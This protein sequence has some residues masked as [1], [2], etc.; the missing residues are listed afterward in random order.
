[1]QK[2]EEEKKELAE[3]VVSLT[4]P[5]FNKQF[6]NIN[7][8]NGL[9]DKVNATHEALI[10]VQKVVDKCVTQEDLKEIL[11]EQTTT[12]DRNFQNFQKMLT[13][14]Q[15]GQTETNNR[16]NKLQ[17]D[18]VQY[19]EDQKNINSGLALTLKQGLEHINTTIQGLASNQDFILRLAP[20][21][22]GWLTQE[23]HDA[24]DDNQ[25]HNVN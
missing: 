6:V 10:S 14:Y 1:V 23:E 18:F 3:A 5:I 20:N 15:E 17:T 4:L 11:K 24:P 21:V 2:T 12:I 25:T 9:T 7:G 22:A 16:F 13:Q 8:F 19:Q